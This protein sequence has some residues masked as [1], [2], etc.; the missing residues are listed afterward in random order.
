[1]AHGAHG[2]YET[3]LIRNSPLTIRRPR[4]PCARYEGLMGKVDKERADK[5]GDFLYRYMQARHRFK[6]RLE[7]PLLY[8]GPCQAPP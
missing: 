7:R 8:R 2:C 6:D 5:V 1:M 3:R 4:S